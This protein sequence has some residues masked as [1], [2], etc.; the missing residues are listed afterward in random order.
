MRTIFLIG[1]KHSGKTS[2]GKA[3][4]GHRCGSFI[5]LDEM[6]E[7]RTGKSPRTLYKEGPEIFKKAE[8][9]ALTALL[10]SENVNNAMLIVAGGGGLI[11]NSEALA[12]LGAA[13]GKRSSAEGKF[14][15]VYLEVSA[16]TAWKRIKEA[17]EKS[18]ELPPFLNTGNPEETHRALHERRAAAYKALADIVINAENKRPSEIAGEIAEQC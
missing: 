1:P 8:T 12:L 7:T 17:A 14:F 2:A 3:L 13:G 4:A 11:D 16:E 9:E 18:G 10:H 6:I 5:D 15:L